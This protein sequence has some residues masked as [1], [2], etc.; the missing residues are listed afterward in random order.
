[1]IIFSLDVSSTVTG[2]CA[3][4]CDK[5]L[6]YGRISL[7]KSLSLSEKLF[8]FRHELVDIFSRITP[9]RV[10]IE[11]VFFGRNVKVIKTLAKFG[12][13]ANECCF[14]YTNTLPYI[15]DNKTTKAFFGVKSKTDLYLRMCSDLSIDTCR[16]DDYNDVVDAYAQGV[17]YYHKI[18]LGE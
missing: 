8:V 13:V 14:T 16:F 10:V 3:L 15:M 9:D 18:V 2:W 1:M 11:D 4:N 7:D 5:P 12:G 6:D 17:C